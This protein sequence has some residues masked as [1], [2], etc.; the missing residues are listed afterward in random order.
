MLPLVAVQDR[1]PMIPQKVQVRHFG[2][3][4]VVTGFMAKKAE[5]AKGKLY[6]HI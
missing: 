4:D 1:V 2:I 5:D 6:L 3:T